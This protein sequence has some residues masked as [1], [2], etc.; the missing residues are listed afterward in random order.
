MLLLL[1]LLAVGVEVGEEAVLGAP[2]QAGVGVKAGVST[3][4]RK[5]D[6]E[7][8]ACSAPHHCPSLPEAWEDVRKCQF[9][10]SRV[11]GG[12]GNM[13]THLRL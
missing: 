13:W 4:V 10:H 3:L 5:L 12:R 11:P 2:A 8:P 6:V 1:L 9:L 7:A